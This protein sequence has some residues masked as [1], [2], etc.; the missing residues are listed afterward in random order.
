MS[1]TSATIGSPLAPRSRSSKRSD[2]QFKWLLVAP[3]AVLILAISIYPLLFSIWVLFVNY[4]FQIPGHAFVGL[5][6]FKQVIYDPVAVSSL[7]VTVGLTVANVAVEFLIGLGLALA[8]VKTFRGRGIIISILIVPLFISPVIVGQAWAMLLQRPFGPTNY[9]LGLL[10]GQE[11]TINWL[12]QWP[13][14][15]VALVMADVW[16]WTPFIFVILLAGLTSIPPHVYEAAEIDGVGPWDTFWYI[17]VPYIAPMML[18]AVTFRLLDAIRLFDTIFVMTA[19]GP[20]T[21]TYTAS[22]YLYIVGFTQFHLSRATAGAWIFLILTLIVV[23]VLVRRLLRP[24]T[25]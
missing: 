4:D 10:L 2:R 23:Q 3:A 24:E 14:N 18:L 6:N 13:W 21:Q 5:K 9:L 7:W 15:F 8:M 17:T 12:T 1:D 19:G 22:Y 11:V 20:G 25:R 16:Q